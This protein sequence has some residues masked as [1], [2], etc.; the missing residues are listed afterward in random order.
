MTWIVNKTAEFVSC[1]EDLALSELVLTSLDNWAVTV[2][3]VQTNKTKLYF[4]SPKNN[5]EIWTARIPD[6]DSNRGASGGFR[7][8]YFFNNIDCSIHLDKIEKRANLGNK[9]EH[10]RDQQKHTA[11][12]DSLKSFLLRELDNI[13]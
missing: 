6:P 3:K 10:P 11:Y 12:L 1:A 5:F 9:T 8:V 2:G 7:L 13:Q 4:R